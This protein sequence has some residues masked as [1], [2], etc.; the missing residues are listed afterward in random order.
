MA[1]HNYDNAAYL[2]FIE[3]L[4]EILKNFEISRLSCS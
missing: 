2:N 1:N 3:D 4:N